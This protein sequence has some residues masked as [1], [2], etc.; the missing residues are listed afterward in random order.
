MDNLTHKNKDALLADLRMSDFARQDY[1]FCKDLFG[2]DTLLKCFDGEN[3]KV[4]A[5]RLLLDH[6]MTL[7]KSVSTYRIMMVMVP[8]FLGGDDDYEGMADFFV[9]LKGGSDD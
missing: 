9:S 2:H 3:V 8:Y 6:F 7:D 4:T 5:S 1:E